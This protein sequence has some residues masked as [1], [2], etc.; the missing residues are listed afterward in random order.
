MFH[1][2][3]IENCTKNLPNSIFQKIVI[4]LN[5]AFI[6]M[7]IQLSILHLERT[8]DLKIKYM[9]YLIIY[10]NSISNYL[11]DSF[12]RIY[13]RHMVRLLR[14]LVL[15]G[16]CGWILGVFS[17]KRVDSRSFYIT[18]KQQHIWIA[19]GLL[20]SLQSI[21]NSSNVPTLATVSFMNTSVNCF[22]PCKTQSCMRNLPCFLLI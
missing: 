20:Q 14:Q 17:W 15:A 21:E 10:Q 6:K 22:S 2:G 11:K 4:I 7:H 16:G 13:A 8:R 9:S 5:S 19:F 18:L 12:Y 1:K 3:K